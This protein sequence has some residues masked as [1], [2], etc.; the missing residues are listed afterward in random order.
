MKA[1]PNSAPNSRPV[2]SNAPKVSASARL[3]MVQ[4]EPHQRGQPKRL[5][6]RLHDLRRQEVVAHPVLRKLTGHEAGAAD[7]REAERQGTRGST[8][9]STSRS[10]APTGIAAARSTS[11]P[12]RSQARGKFCT[13]VRYCGI[14]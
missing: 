13:V 1:D 12:R 14:R 6:Q 3:Q 2:C 10:A 9:R 7:E 8:K 5:A 11:A 4:K